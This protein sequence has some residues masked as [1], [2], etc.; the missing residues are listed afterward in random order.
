MTAQIIPFPR[1]A[2]ASRNESIA[3]AVDNNRRQYAPMPA[4]I[5]RD[6]ALN[7][8]VTELQ[9]KGWTIT[10]YPNDVTICTHPQVIAFHE[11]SLLEAW[12]YQQNLEEKQA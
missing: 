8:L 6:P 7:R 10:A 1:T 12:L 9:D 2:S 5:T 3:H 11:I 4:R